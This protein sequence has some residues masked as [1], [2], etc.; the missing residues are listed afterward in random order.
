MGHDLEAPYVLEE[1]LAA[2]AWRGEVVLA[3]NAATLTAIPTLG[4]A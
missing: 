4:L 3:T 2:R 1:A